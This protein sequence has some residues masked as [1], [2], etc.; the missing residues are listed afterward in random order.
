M[1]RS[2]LHVFLP[3]MIWSFLMHLMRLLVLYEL[4]RRILSVT[5]N[6]IG[7]MTKLA[8]A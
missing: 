4:L 6:M 3:D 8:S 1:A 7:W 5:D 2:N